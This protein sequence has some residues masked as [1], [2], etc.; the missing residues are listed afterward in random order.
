MDSKITVI[1]NG[2]HC[3]DEPQPVYMGSQWLWKFDDGHKDNDCNYHVG[4]ETEAASSNRP[5]KLN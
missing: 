5:G 3:A 4:Q 2:S 1:Q